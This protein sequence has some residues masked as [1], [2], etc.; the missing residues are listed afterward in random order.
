MIRYFIAKHGHSTRVIIIRFTNTTSY[1]CV[2]VCVCVCACVC[3]RVCVCVCACVCV[4]VCACV[5]AMH[6]FTEQMQSGKVT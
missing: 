5:H 2:C 1:L 6:V 4:C 3:V